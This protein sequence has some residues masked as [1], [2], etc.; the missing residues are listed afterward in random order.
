M[1]EALYP[2]PPTLY[3]VILISII[4]YS[5]FPSHPNPGTVTSLWSEVRTVNTKL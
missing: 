2:L 5:L 1:K 3:G 4:P